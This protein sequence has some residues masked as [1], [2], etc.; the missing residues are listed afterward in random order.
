M[1]KHEIILS[2]LVEEL[3]KLAIECNSKERLHSEEDF[4][5]CGSSTVLPILF[6][7]W[8]EA[9]NKWRYFYDLVRESAHRANCVMPD[10]IY[11]DDPNK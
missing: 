3:D 8:Q 2:V 4:H 1:K 10:F 6:K 5:S 7:D 9:Y 11:V